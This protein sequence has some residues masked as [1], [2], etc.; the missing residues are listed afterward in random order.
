MSVRAAAAG[1][2]VLLLAVAAGCASGRRPPGAGPAA[3][4]A[5]FGT[6]P[7]RVAQR[8][9]ACALAGRL[10][11]DVAAL[12]AA[13]R[14]AAPPERPVGMDRVAIPPAALRHRIRPGETLAGL[15]RW[16]GHPVAV[17]AAKNNI[18]DPHRINAGIWLSIPPGARTGCAPEA[19]AVAKAGP[20]AAAPR[21]RPPARVRPPAEPPAVAAPP[22]APEPEP[23]EALARADAA[24]AEAGRRYDAAD[25]ESA[26]AWSEEAR[27]AVEGRGDGA[28]LERRARAHWMAGL[29]N[30]GLDR[31]D[32][33]RAALREALAL[34]PSL[35]REQTVSPRI[36]GL[37][38]EA[39]G[40]EP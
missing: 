27:R 17:L 7:V 13:N 32:E 10:G 35:R 1:G 9:T 18:P 34:R 6:G 2:V 31:R 15:A 25:F 22:P 3:A 30:A 8:E 36:L 23:T 29:A 33:A 4:P 24:L 12:R 14:L 5:A 40:G 19:P 11:V 20:A 38:E 26:L 28:S 39:P 37:L 16:Y 21:A